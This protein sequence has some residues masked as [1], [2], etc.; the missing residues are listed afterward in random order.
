LDFFLTSETVG[1][2]DMGGASTQITYLPDSS[3]TLPLEYSKELLLY[4][5]TYNV[6]THSFTCY[7]LMEAHRR[8]LGQLVKVCIFF[9]LKQN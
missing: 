7:G 5:S 6:Y 8:Y 2:L 4:G 3:V 9:M 1:A